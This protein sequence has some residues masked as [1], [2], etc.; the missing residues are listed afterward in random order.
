MEMSLLVAGAK[1]GLHRRVMADCHTAGVRVI[2]VTGDQA[3]TARKVAEAVHLSPDGTA[4]QRRAGHADEKIQ[5]GSGRESTAADRSRNC[6][7]ENRT[8]S[9]QGSRST[10]QTYYCWGGENSG[11]HP[12]LTH[13]VAVFRCRDWRSSEPYAF[14]RLCRT[15]SEERRDRQ[16]FRA[17]SSCRGL[18]VS[19]ASRQSK[20]TDA[21]QKSHVSIW[22]SQKDREHSAHCLCASCEQSTVAHRIGSMLYDHAKGVHHIS[23]NKMAKRPHQAV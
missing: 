20:H 1:A 4:L 7:R 16:A 12:P 18:F 3:I 14:L 21:W 17:S 22:S 10:Q 6:G 23:T 2:M 8:A 15:S 9:L 5:T 13:A 11:P 19:C